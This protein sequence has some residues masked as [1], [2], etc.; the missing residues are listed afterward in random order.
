MDHN[1]PP[2]PTPTTTPF[3]MGVRKG[4]RKLSE[5]FALKKSQ[6]Q[7]QDREKLL[8]AGVPEDEVERVLAQQEYQSLPVDKRLQR[9]EQMMAGGFSELLEQYHKAIK[10]TEG[11]AGDVQR[12]SENDRDIADVLDINFRAFSKALVSLGCSPEQQK[13][14][15]EEAQKE[16][17]AELAERAARKAEIEKFQI[18]RDAVHLVKEAVEAPS[19]KPEETP[20]P[21][22]ATVFGG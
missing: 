12:L 15:M 11:L 22:G 3:P 21:D 4:P 9:L 18:D 20:L 10:N 19:T 5:M 13:G 7:L 1:A 8:K 14:L 6:K 16:I 2:A 17:D